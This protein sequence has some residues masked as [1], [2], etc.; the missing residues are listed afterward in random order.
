MFRLQ[1]LERG[2]LQLLA[3]HGVASLRDKRILEI[4]CG[5]GHWLRE[6]VKWGAD[7]AAVTGLDL[8]LDSVAVARKLC[9][10]GTGLSS[11]SG[12]ALPFSDAVFD[13]VAL[14]TVFTSILDS[15]LKRCVAGE[16]VRVLKSRGL[17]V[18]YDFHVAN[19]ANPDVRPVGR[20]EITRLFPG[21]RVT[22]R[23]VTLAPPWRGSSRGDPGPCT[24][25]SKQ[26]PFSGPTTSASSRSPRGRSP[27]TRA[28]RGPVSRAAG[29]YSNRSPSHS[30]ATMR[31]AVLPSQRS[32]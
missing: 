31:S 24:R 21:C 23:R 25:C 10:V 30:T 27:I 3:E 6:F 14:F 29:G 22:L 8:L 20:R 17:V 4:G 19:P 11:G 13:V 2:V 16:A 12:A 15:E 5:T 32:T 7:P 1:G 26:S 18:W 9:A 28:R